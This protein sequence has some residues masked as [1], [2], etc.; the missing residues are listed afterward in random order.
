MSTPTLYER[1][2]HCASDAPLDL[3]CMSAWERAS[4]VV[5]RFDELAVGQSLTYLSEHDPRALAV[6]FDQM[7][8]RQSAWEYRHLGEAEWRAT[9]TRVESEHVERSV[10]GLLRRSTT[11]GGLDEATREQLA[12][13]SS[14]HGARKGDTIAPENADFPYVGIVWE[15][16]LALFSGA[17][18]RER[19][20]YE[21]FTFET[22][23]AAGFFD[24][25]MTLGRIAV[26][27]KTARYVT[28]PRE[29]VRQLGQRHPQILVA[30]GTL[31]A[32]RSRALAE[33]LTAQASQPIIARI[34]AALLQYA[35]PERGLHPVLP[36]LADMTQSQVAAAAGTVKGVAARAIAELEARLA[37]RR[38]RGHIRYLDRERLLEI[39]THV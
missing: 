30:I 39:A 37:L 28:I 35:A 18:N 26:L 22:F 14:E 17:P 5:S 36:P 13:A 38:E 3:R 15:G 10:A 27:S 31:C 19:L 7:R 4:I 8:P 21:Y 23:G 32:Q 20:L 34:A 1:G 29:A 11:F 2:R 24:D 12:A 33:A 25:G 9:V 16:T 6:R